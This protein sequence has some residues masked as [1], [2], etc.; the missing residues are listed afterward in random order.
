ML[1]SSWRYTSQKTWKLQIWHGIGSDV[2][3]MELEEVQNISEK[4]RAG[5]WEAPVHVISEYNDFAILW[6][7][8]FFAWFRGTIMHNT[9]CGQV[10]D[11]DKIFEW[12]LGDDRGNP[13]A[14]IDCLWRHCEE[15]KPKGKERF[16][17]S[18]QFVKSQVTV[19]VYIQ[20]GG[21]S[22]D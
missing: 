1:G 11:F 14:C 3:R 13:I 16:A 20:N 15:R 5:W 18:D 7:R 9:L 22:E 4:L 6:L 2:L 17:G 19:I 21:L 12:A 8:Y 10:P